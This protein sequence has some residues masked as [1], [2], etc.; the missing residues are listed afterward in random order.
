V[1]VVVEAKGERL[2]IGVVEWPSKWHNADAP[3]SSLVDGTG[4]V[5]S[6]GRWKVPFS[7]DLLAADLLF[8]C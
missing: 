1:E 8:G 4:V 6:G 7:L 2:D 3:G 5:G